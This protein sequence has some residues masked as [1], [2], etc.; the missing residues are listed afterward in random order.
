MS[1]GNGKFLRGVFWLLLIGSFSWATVIGAAS[2]SALNAH[3]KD[4]EVKSS[5]LKN[6]MIFRDESALKEITKEFK[7]INTVLAELRTDVKY[8]RMKN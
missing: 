4:A 3:C 5:E 7:E 2:F 6:E 8:L 1:D